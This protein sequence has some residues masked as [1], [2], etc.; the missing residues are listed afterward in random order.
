MSLQ[1]ARLDHVH[2]VSFRIPAF[3]QSLARLKNFPLEVFHGF[4]QHA[5]LDA[6][7]EGVRLET[8]QQARDALGADGR[9]AEWRAAP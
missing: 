3:E 2:V 8:R 1:L 4:A 6:E 9:R 5:R 7:E